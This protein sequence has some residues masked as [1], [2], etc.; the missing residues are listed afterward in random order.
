MRLSNRPLVLVVLLLAATWVASS[1]AAADSDYETEP[2]AHST[3]DGAVITVST[4]TPASDGGSG[5]GPAAP[6]PW[7]NCFQADVGYIPDVL[8]IVA[9]LRPF[10][11]VG[12]QFDELQELADLPPSNYTGVTTY[13]VCDRA[14][15]TGPAAWLNR[16]GSPVDPTPG[17]IIE[18]ERILTLPE[19]EIATSPPQGSTQPVGLPVWFWT[20]NSHTQTRSASVPGVTV[21]VTA[22]PSRLDLSI[23]EPTSRRTGVT[24]TTSLTCRG[25]GTPYD[26][27]LHQ[28]WD[29][30]DCSH[31][32]DWPGTATVTATVTWT[33]AWQSS[34]GASGILDPV[35]RTSTVTLEPTELQAV[36]D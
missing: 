36:L 14:D 13:T 18:A 8:A 5:S 33:L 4:G 17:L 19:P 31:T 3:D 26:P 10:G 32:F 9:P 2:P 28:P 24:R 27:A 30:S 16:P 21:T 22:T 11:I 6:S 15:G 1:P 23:V 12:P 25:T 7:T 35:A 20:T 29:R 34:T